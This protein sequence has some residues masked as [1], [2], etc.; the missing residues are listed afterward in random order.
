MATCEICKE[1]LREI[2][3]LHKLIEKLSENRSAVAEETFDPMQGIRESVEEAESSEQPTEV[4]DMSD[5]RKAFH[6]I[7]SSDPYDIAFKKGW[8]AEENNAA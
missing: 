2:N 7:H 6:E 4:M 3:R 1:R 5:V 8:D